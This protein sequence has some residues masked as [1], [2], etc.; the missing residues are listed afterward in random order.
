MVSVSSLKGE[1][2]GSNPIITTNPKN[3]GVVA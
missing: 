2:I 1:D 3:N